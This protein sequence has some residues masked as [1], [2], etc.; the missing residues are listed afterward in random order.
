[1]GYEEIIIIM[2]KKTIFIID[3]NYIDKYK[4][5]SSFLNKKIVIYD[6]RYDHIEKHKYEFSSIFEYDNALSSIELIIAEPDFIVIDD[7][8]KGIEFI[9]TLNDNILIAVRLSSSAEL[10]IKSLYP[11][12]E[13]K[14][15]RLLLKKTN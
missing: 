5:D 12:N 1:M 7:K 3:Q 8:K 14:R 10:K 4:L 15:K 11:I 6:D 2:K 9:K 13:V